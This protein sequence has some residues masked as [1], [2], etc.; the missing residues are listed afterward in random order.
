M[1][2]IIIMDDKIITT[3]SIR[4]KE[5]EDK[6]YFLQCLCNKDWINLKTCKNHK[7]ALEE[8]KSIKGEMEKVGVFKD[9]VSSVFIFI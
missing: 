8:I 5:T 1:N 9:K 2:I 7:E 6:K 4:L 3:N